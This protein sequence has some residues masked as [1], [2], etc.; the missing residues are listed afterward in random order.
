LQRWERTRTL[1]AASYGAS[2]AAF[3]PP[4]GGAV[5]TAFRDDSVWVRVPFSRVSKRIPTGSKEKKLG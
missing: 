2:A 5:A 3:V 4:G 1:G